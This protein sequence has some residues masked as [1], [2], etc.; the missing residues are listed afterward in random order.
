MIAETCVTVRVCIRCT[1]RTPI[2]RVYNLVL[3]LRL[4][5]RQIR[6]NS[7]ETWGSVHDLAASKGGYSRSMPNV[8]CSGLAYR[9]HSWSS[10]QQGGSYPRRRLADTI[11][12]RIES[13]S[14]SIPGDRI[15]YIADPIH[16]DR[17]RAGSDLWHRHGRIFF[18]TH[19]RLSLRGEV[20]LRMCSMNHRGNV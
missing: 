4:I 16:P 14:G 18:W 12:G 10:R 15:R 8:Q 3:K 5:F 17:Y 1:S 11:R 2:L 19:F 9:N 7:T 13:A 6:Y 20:L